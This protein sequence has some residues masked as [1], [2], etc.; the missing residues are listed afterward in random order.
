[1]SEIVWIQGHCFLPQSLSEAELQS[2]HARLKPLLLTEEG[3]MR[4]DPNISLTRAAFTMSETYGRPAQFRAVRSIKTNHRCGYV[5]F[6]KPS[7]AE[8]LFQVPDDLPEE[9]N[10]YVIHT[11]DGIECFSEGD[12]HRA[13]TVF[14][15][16]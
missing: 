16:I 9:C 8:V 15:V 10:A 2:R 14:G 11:E 1:M 5:A 7:I 6:F 12:G 4:V 3:Y 13:T